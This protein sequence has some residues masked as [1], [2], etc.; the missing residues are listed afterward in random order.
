MGSALWEFLW[1]LDRVTD[2]KDGIGLVL[3]GKP[4]RVEEIMADVPGSDRE[5]VRQHMIA[6]ADQKYIRRVRT[7][8]GYRIEVLNSN[9]QNVWRKREEQK[10]QNLVSLPKTE[11]KKDG[12][13]VL[14]KPQKAVGETVNHGERNC[15]LG[16]SK[17][18]TAVD[19]TG[20]TAA[21]ASKI[22]SELGIKSWELP[23][24]F[25]EMLVLNR[26]TNPR[27]S[28]LKLLA[29]TMNAW[30][31]TGN[32]HP[33]AAAKAAARLRLAQKSAAPTSAAEEIPV[34]QEP[35]WLR[36]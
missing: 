7:P 1:C 5:T 15:L 22:C 24:G 12:I 10:P 21:A 9:K 19:T 4:V 20:D 23:P 35:E 29:D 8:Y 30:Q 6:L 36:Q 17:E 13:S 28:P 16:V 11:T 34:L 14:E 33:P 25:R 32:S 27:Q 2:E 18:D 3:G 31:D 26:A